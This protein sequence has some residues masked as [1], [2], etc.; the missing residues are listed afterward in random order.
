MSSQD[1]FNVIQMTRQQYIQN[2]VDSMDTKIAQFVSGDT[3]VLQKRT[4]DR[5][6]LKMSENVMK[7][8]WDNKLDDV[9]DKV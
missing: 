5:D 9:W 7:K 1:S 3:G 4:I 6:F 8:I 2:S